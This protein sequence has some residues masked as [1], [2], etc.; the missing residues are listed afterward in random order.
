LFGAGGAATAIAFH[1]AKEVEELIILN[2]RPEKAKNL[3]EALRRK[4]GKT[5]EGNS[6][7]ASIIKEEL[8]NSDVL[9]NATSV[10]MHQNFDQSLVDLGWLRPDLC[11][12]DIIYNPLETKLAKNAK[13][14]G[15]KVISG[16]EMLVY[17]GA[18]S[19]E[20]WTN[21]AAPIKAMKQAV[22]NKLSE[23]GVIY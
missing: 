7:S 5:I 20:I 11:V 8:K 22:L 2:R 12:M 6:L 16:I 17:Q 4:F 10:G 15:A 1:V 9:I 3:A 14:K 13:S 19:F 18:A 23:T 21:Q